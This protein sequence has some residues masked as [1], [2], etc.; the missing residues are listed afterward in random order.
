MHHVSV[1][2]WALVFAVVSEVQ[3][4]LGSDFSSVDDKAL[5]K[6]FE[7]EAVLNVYRGLKVSP[8]CNMGFAIGSQPCFAKTDSSDHG[9]G[10]ALP[11]PPVLRTTRRGGG[12]GV[13]QGFRPQTVRADASRPSLHLYLC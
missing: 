3:D 12:V 5:M 13:W 8:T 7:D 1:S 2:V 4:A 11:P 9:H 10:F 6:A